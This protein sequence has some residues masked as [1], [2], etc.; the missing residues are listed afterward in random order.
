MTPETAK[1]L[2]LLTEKGRDAT[3][4]GEAKVESHEAMVDSYSIGEL[5]LSRQRFDVLDL[6]AIQKAFGFKRLDGI[7]GFDVLKKSITCIDNEK[8]LL[9]LKNGKADC[10]GPQVT[11]IPFRLDH[12]TPVIKGSVNGIETEF[13][14][15]TGDRSAF[16]LFRKFAHKSDLEQI[17]KDRP[18]V[19]SGVGVGGAIP[20]KMATL[21]EIKLGSSL[22]IENVL[23]RMPTTKG[24]YFARST[25]GGGVGNEILRRFNLILDYSRNE[26]SLLKNSHF[27][28]EFK[29]RGPLKN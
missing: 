26:I 6:S 5:T 1:A 13:I 19:I 14:V 15:D 8:Q 21:R 16:S 22:K 18:E 7:V 24:G 27:E 25:L 10:F 9:I 29:F 23:T 28:D 4:A 11:V 2:G 12:D 20:A 3:G 17:F